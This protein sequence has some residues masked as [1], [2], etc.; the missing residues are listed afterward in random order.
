MAKEESIALLK[1][2]A[3]LGDARTAL[4][5]LVREILKKRPA[6]VTKEPRSVRI[7]RRI[8]TDRELGELINRLQAVRDEM[9]RI[10]EIEITLE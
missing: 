2:K 7:P 6:P 5:A 1:E 10:S 3:A 8:T 4:P 9:D